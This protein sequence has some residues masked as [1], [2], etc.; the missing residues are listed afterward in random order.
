MTAEPVQVEELIAARE[1]LVTEVATGS[2]SV[3]NHLCFSTLQGFARFHPARLVQVQT[4]GK[5]SFAPPT[6]AGT[7]L[8][9]VRRGGWICSI[10]SVFALSRNHPAGHAFCLRHLPA[11]PHFWC[12]L[13]ALDAMQMSWIQQHT[14]F[15]T[16][17]AILGASN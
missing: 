4:S 8:L 10:A 2:P 3:I 7:T 6:M 5:G 15:S 1:A 11:H 9:N 16:N 12:S 13:A 17:R 14:D